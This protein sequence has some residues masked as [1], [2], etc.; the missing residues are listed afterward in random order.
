MRCAG[1]PADIK[2]VDAFVSVLLCEFRAAKLL[3]EED[4]AVGRAE[5][6]A[7]F[8]TDMDGD[9]CPHA[10]Q[11]ESARIDGRQIDPRSRQIRSGHLHDA[12]VGDADA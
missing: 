12:I 10:G 5:N 8:V 2:P 6:T 9:R 7:G 1:G 11:C 4:D 3:A